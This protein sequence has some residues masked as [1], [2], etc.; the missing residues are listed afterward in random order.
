MSIILVFSSVILLLLVIVVVFIVLIVV[1][2]HWHSFSAFRHLGIHDP[3]FVLRSVKYSRVLTN[4][5][6]FFHPVYCAQAVR[7]LQLS[8]GPQNNDEDAHIVPTSSHSD[9]LV[10]ENPC[11]FGWLP[12]VS[13]KFLSCQRNRVL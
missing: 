4:N 13:D 2:H 1:V 9:R 7:K 6:L 12:P 10:A 3:S 11:N 5:A 8:E